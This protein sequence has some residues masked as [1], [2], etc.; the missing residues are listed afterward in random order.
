MRPSAQWGQIIPAKLIPLKNARWAFA[1]KRLRD[2]WARAR[3]AAA[4]TRKISTS[5]ESV[6]KPENV[7]EA[8]KLFAEGMSKWA[9]QEWVRSAPQRAM[10]DSLLQKLRDG[11][12]EACGVQ[13]AP[14]QLREVE[15]IPD[16]FF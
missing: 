15:I 11:N 4:R 3:K 10:Q 2:E 8:V 5:P 14:K 7:A 13:F 9:E 6:Q 16:H 12:L 1:S